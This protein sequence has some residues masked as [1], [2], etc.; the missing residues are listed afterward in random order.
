M[1]LIIPD[2]IPS[3]ASQGE[4]LLFKILSTQLPDNF[5]VWYEPRIKDLYPDFIILGPDFGLLI[6][7]VKGWYASQVARGNNNFFDIRWKQNNIVKIETYQHPLKQGHGYFGSVA[8]QLKGYPILCNPDGNYQGQSLTP[9]AGG[10]Y[11]STG[12]SGMRVRP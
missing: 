6:L 10:N 3:K 9:L 11:Q 2:A 5:I 4:Q 7:E 8:D 12:R 1:A